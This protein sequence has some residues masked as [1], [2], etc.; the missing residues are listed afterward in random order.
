MAASATP[1]GPL[2]DPAARA[3]AAGSG[4]R[5]P[6]GFAPLVP[7]FA[8]T[9]LA[10]SLRFWCGPLGFTVAYDRPAAG[11]AYLH[12]GQLQVMLCQ[13]NGCWETGEMEYP[14]GRGMNMQMTVPRLAPILDALDALGWPL[15]E[16][17]SEAWY[18][19]GDVEGGQ[20]EFL[21]QDPD[22]YLLRFAEDLGTRDPR[23]P[24]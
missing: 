23:G 16:A 12:R 19:T 2:A 15:F 18:R 6:G 8:V 22:G 4:A 11:F 3:A 9:D 21:V 14:L 7:E 13:R 1:P 5:P 10:A 20:R 17:P 24:Q